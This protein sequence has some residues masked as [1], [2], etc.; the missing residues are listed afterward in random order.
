MDIGSLVLRYLADASVRSLGLALTALLA[1]WL[2]RARSAAVRHAVW[3]AVVCAMLSLP[4]LSVTL[5]S[6]PVRILQAAPAVVVPTPAPAKVGGPAQAQAAPAPA[7]RANSPAWMSLLLAAYLLVAAALLGRLLA[8]YVMSRRL[9]GRS[10]PIRDARVSELLDRLA[11]ATAAGLAESQSIAVPLTVGWIKPHILLPSGWQAWDR[12]KLDAVLTHEFAHVRRADWLVALLAG[13]NRCVFWFHPLAWWMERKLAALAEDSCDESSLLVTGNRQRYAQVL[14]EMAD[15]VRAGKGRLNWHAVAMARP[16]QVR[17]RI[18]AILDESRL[19]SRGMTKAR[20]AAVLLCAVPLAYATAAVQLQPAETPARAPSAYLDSVVE[21]RQLTAEQ[22]QSIETYL[23]ANPD[24]VAARGR[25]IAYYYRNGARAP[26]LKHILWLIE[27][28]PESEIAG[29]SSTGISP[30]GG[31]LNDAADYRRARELWLDQTRRNPADA[32]VLANAANFFSQPAADAATAEELLKQLRRLDPKNQIWAQRLA[33][34]YVG[35]ILRPGSFDPGVVEQFKTELEA[36][37]DGMLVVT[38]GRQLASIRSQPPELAAPAIEFGQRLLKRAQELGFNAAP[39]PPGPPS[40]P[41]VAGVPGGP[42][43]AA[44]PAVLQRVEPVYPPLARQARIQGTVQFKVRIGEDGRVLNM[45][46]VSGHPLL[47]PAAQE[48]VKQ[49][50]FQPATKDGQA[51]ETT[52]VVE[53]GFSLPTGSAPASGV[54]GGLPNVTSPIVLQRVPPVYP[55]LARQARVSGTVRVS[56]RIGQD[57]R[58]LETQRVSGPPLLTQA[59]QEAVLQW[60]FQPPMKDGQAIEFTA[61]IEVNFALP[62]DSAPPPTA[63]PMKIRVG[64]NV[65]AA[66]LLEKV[67]P[68]YPPAAKEAGIE[69]TVRFTATIDVDGHVKDLQLESGHPLLVDAAQEAVRQW[70]YRPTLL[71]GEPVEV[72]T[73][74][75]VSFSLSQ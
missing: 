16:S 7:S 9:V 21:G 45:Q 71:N 49:W 51:V 68:A 4:L 37:T 12:A 8:G 70:V 17:Q 69:G 38:T 61:E 15:A 73:Q 11:I 10:Q 2:V 26:R 41:P 35:A 27:H 39:L 32:R 14:L 19:L 62:A 57:G 75:D 58:V 3:T 54:P 46:L 29:F 50:V 44:Y 25:L 55:A 40:P 13:L 5:P 20:W 22:A 43:S 63:A 60:V 28:H 52:A 23:L 31:I 72:I 56:V 42:P 47:V 1:L 74:I 48:A 6:I 24:D 36:S 18:E 66:N 30:T 65:Q 59:A 64:G 33:S 67:K 34:L 53:V